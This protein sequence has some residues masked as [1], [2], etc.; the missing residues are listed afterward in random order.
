MTTLRGWLRVAAL[1]AAATGGALVGF[2]IRRGAPAVLLSAAG[3]RLRGVPSFVA[4]DRT[5]GASALLGAAHHLAASLAWGLT[6][7]ALAAGGRLRGASLAAVAL[8][9]GALAVT[10]DRVL[11]APLALAAGVLTAPQ[12][13]VLGLVLAATL[14]VG[15]LLAQR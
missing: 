15:T 9:V 7:A 8:L 1:G 3:E 4:P 14:G 10:V 2:G 12:R 5:L 6:F 11:P 13:V